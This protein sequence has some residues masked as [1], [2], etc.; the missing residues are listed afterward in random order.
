M[1]RV[2]VLLL[3]SVLAL[4]A[5]G[6]GSSKSSSTPSGGAGTSQTHFAKT[7]FVLHAGLAFGAFHRWIYKPFKAGDFS[8]PFRHKLT[9]V[10]ALLAASFIHHEVVLARADARHSRLLSK[11]VLPLLGISGAILAI[12]AAIAAHHAP[13]ASNVSSANSAISSVKSDSSAA[14]QPIQETT[15]GAH[16]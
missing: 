13:S 8:H 1:R 10:K 4:G 15:A 5:V 12:R 16:V 9:I 11:V 3:V 2:I 6:C 14:G 7:K